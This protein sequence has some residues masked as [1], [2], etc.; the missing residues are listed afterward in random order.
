MVKTQMLLLLSGDVETNPGPAREKKPDP[1]KIMEDKVNSHDEKI[2]ALE[3]LV[4]DQK[5]MLEAMTEKQV[6]LQTALEDS[7][8]EFSKSMEDKKT[9]TD[10]TI[11]ELNT[12]VEKIKSQLSGSLSQLGSSTQDTSS[13]MKG[14]ETALEDLQDKLWELDKSWENNLVFYGITIMKD[15]EDRPQLIES[16]VR[17]ILRINLGIARD[18]PILRVKRAHTGSNIRGSKPVTVYFQKYEDKEEILRKTQFLAGSNIYIAEDFS[19]K[20]KDRR[21]EL[22]KFMRRMKKKNPLGKFTMRYDK[23]MVD[24]DIYTFNEIT[25]QV[26]LTTPGMVADDGSMSPTSSPTT[27]HHPRSKSRSKSSG[28]KK[29]LE[30]SYSTDSALNF[31]SDEAFN[32]DSREP[33]PTK[34][35][36]PLPEEEVDQE[37]KQVELDAKSRPSSPGQEEGDPADTE[38][39]G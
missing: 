13:K 7:K 16:R 9:A 27:P 14:M 29:K 20:V 17:E 24:K 22:Q 23:L 26:E 33:S 36:T 35:I 2:A 38:A 30:K 11:E 1:K 34:S 31:L 21:T 39:N 25:G 4:T 8:V 37:I 15:E 3:K 32:G 28:R 12:E 6:E 5:K 10:Q 19:K 18:V